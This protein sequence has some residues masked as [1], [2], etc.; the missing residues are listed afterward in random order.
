MAY[1]GRTRTGQPIYGPP[2]AL[3]RFFIF[4]DNFGTGLGVSSVPRP[5]S[6][7]VV[8]WPER[9]G[10]TCFLVRGDEQSQ[11]QPFTAQSPVMD[12]TTDV[13]GVYCEEFEG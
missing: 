6:K 7:A 10:I 13:V 1:L 11:P 3:Q 8:I 2:N 4:N 5:V 12:T 9:D